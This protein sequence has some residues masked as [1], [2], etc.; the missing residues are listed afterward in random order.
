MTTMHA[1][2][3]T[4]A[5]V[6]RPDK[7]RR[8]GGAAAANLLPATAGAA[9]ATAKGCPIF[10]ENSM[11][12]RSACRCPSAR[13]RISYTSLRDQSAS[14]RSTVIFREEAASDRYPEFV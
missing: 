9:R 5:L 2:A 11:A 14:R 12:S 8:R 1:Y 4:Q 3:A 13:S 6:D 10:E 7:D